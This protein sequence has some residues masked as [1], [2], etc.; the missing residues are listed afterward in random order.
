MQKA[1]RREGALLDLALFAASLVPLALFAFLAF[2][3]YQR[4]EAE[5]QAAVRSRVEVLRGHMSSL[6]AVNVALLH[7]VKEHFD[8]L[9]ARDI[10]RQP[11]EHH[12]YLASL[13]DRHPEVLTLSI[14]GANGVVLAHSAAPIPPQVSVGERDYFSTHRDHDGGV[15]VSTPQVS[16]V[17]QQPGFVL[18]LRRSRADGA[19]DGVYAAT[20]RS[21]YLSDFWEDIARYTGLDDTV[22]L[23]RADGVVLARFPQTVEGAQRLDPGNPL[24]AFMRSGRS[25]GLWRAKWA[26]DGRERISASRKLEGV[27]LYVNYAV[28]TEAALAPWRRDMLMMG[29]VATAAS[30]LLAALSLLV[31]RRTRNLREANRALRAAEGQFR[32]VADAAPVMLWITGPRGPEFVSRSALEFAGAGNPGLPRYRLVRLIHPEDRAQLLKAYGEAY[33]RGEPFEGMA[34]LRRYDGAYRW[35][36]SLGVPRHGRDGAM[37]GYVGASFDVQEL[38]EAQQSLRESDRRKDEFLAALSHELRNPLS[39]ITLSTEV[40][41]RTPIRDPQG[42]NA[43]HIISRQLGQLQRMVDDLLDTARATFDKLVLARHPVEALSLSRTV[44]TALQGQHGQHRHIRVQGEQAWVNADPAR[45]QQMLGN[46]IEN[47]VKYG[48]TNITVEV[49]AA[50]DSVELAVKDDGEGIPAELLPRLFQPFAQG[51]QS[52]ERARGGLGLGL[53]LVHR[54]A[55]LHGGSVHAES[56]GSGRGSR[57]VIRL[58]RGAA[59]AG[60]V[61]A[62]QEVKRMPPRRVLIVEDQADARDSLRMLLELDG[63]DVALAGDGV[64]GLAKMASMHPDVALVDIGLPGIDGYE[65][66]RRA[67][68]LPNRQGFVLVALSGYAQREDREKSRQA[69]FDLHLAKPVAYGE[70]RQALR[71]SFVGVAALRQL[72]SAEA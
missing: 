40:L 65:V 13:R 19:F 51:V 62:P 17:A 58:P 28:T 1:S 14:I 64:E 68:E 59:P 66:A 33:A 67:G 32:T 10:A 16:R 30:A 24:A 38:V 49:A 27:P 15:F 44:V 61:S 48:G 43:L 9:E 52:L 37:T 5:A 8:P 57:F 2:Y 41:A 63:H 54:L 12:G 70:L 6:I 36:R 56:G 26:M 25:T 4:A 23:A 39:A 11:R 29:G 21:S 46:L 50:G 7:R 71:M 60:G 3:T 18:S 45:L 22:S 31:R 34:R 20:V 53:A 69:G 47:A 35:M 72:G 42:R 55:T